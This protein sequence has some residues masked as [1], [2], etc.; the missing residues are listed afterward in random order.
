MEKADIHKY[1]NGHLTKMVIVLRLTFGN[2]LPQIK[3]CRNF[4]FFLKCVS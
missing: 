1:V 2:N 4:I 3:I